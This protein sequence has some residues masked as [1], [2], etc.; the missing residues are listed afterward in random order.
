MFAADDVRVAGRAGTGLRVEPADGR[1][2]V[3]RA[4]VGDAVVDVVVRQV[5]IVCAS[6]P[7]AN[8]KIRMPGKPELVAKLLRRRA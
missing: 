8:C 6:P 1:V 3:V 5:V 4:R 7:N 2:V